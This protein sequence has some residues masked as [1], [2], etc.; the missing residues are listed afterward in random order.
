MILNSAHLFS[1]IRGQGVHSGSD[2]LD[3]PFN[4]LLPSEEGFMSGL[5]VNLHSVNSPL[6]SK[7]ELKLQSQYSRHKDGFL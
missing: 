4:M 6:D 2:L 1:V 3:S 5:R 7:Q